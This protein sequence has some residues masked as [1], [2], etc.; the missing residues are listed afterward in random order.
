MSIIVVDR[1]GCVTVS[2][3]DANGD[4]ADYHVSFGT[5]PTASLVVILR[6]NEK[7]ESYVVTRQLK[8]A[9]TCTCKDHE[10]SGFK[11]RGEDCCKHA[12]CCKGLYEIKQL[13]ASAK[14][15]PLGS[16]SVQLVIGGKTIN[17]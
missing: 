16:K 8:G 9:W 6:R 5:N 13:F 14:T 12:E 3:P 1:R 7:D 4:E 17:L 10:F 11:K 2:I 15:A